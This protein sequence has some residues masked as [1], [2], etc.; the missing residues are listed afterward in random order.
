M[1]K[2]RSLSHG[3]RDLQAKMHL[4]REESDRVLDESNDVSDISANLLVQ[5]D[6][7]GEGLRF[8]MQDWHEGREA[9]STSIGKNET[10][11]SLSPGGTIAPMSP[12]SSLGGLTAVDGNSPD[13]F[14]PSN[15]HPRMG[16]SRS[17]TTNSSSGEEVFE[18][19]AL[20]HR[21]S[22]VTREQRIAKIKEDRTRQS[23]AKE[24][25]E[26]Q[27]YMLKELETVIK[28]RPRGRSTGRMAAV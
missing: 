3:I 11:L 8:L 16:R 20:P 6:S 2:L 15:G 22:C 4:L 9:L 25:A 5:Y 1:R 10:R 18:A 13:A 19:V 26:S 21:R 7:V 24:K 12:T 27:T 23:L 28:L 14:K 17:S